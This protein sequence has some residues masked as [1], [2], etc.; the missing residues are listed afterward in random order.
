M[1]ISHLITRSLS[2][3]SR[4]IRIPVYIGARIREMVRVSQ[5]LEMEHGQQPKPDEIA[6]E[7]GESPAKIQGTS[8]CPWTNLTATRAVASSTIS[9]RTKMRFSPKR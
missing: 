9:S 6:A 4:A 5:R 8:R 7:M 3:H 1:P 2:N